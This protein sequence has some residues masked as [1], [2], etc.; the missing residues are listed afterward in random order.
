MTRGAALHADVDVCP[1]CQRPTHASESND[2]GICRACIAASRTTTRSFR[3][4]TYSPD[5]HQHTAPSVVVTVPA[6]VDLND[7]V[8]KQAIIAAA[9]HAGLAPSREQ[10]QLVERLGFL[11]RIR[12]AIVELPIGQ[13]RKQQVR[14]LVGGKAAR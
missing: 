2:E 12:Y 4:S 9:E 1:R 7:R 8:G 6:S 11:P 5:V 13:R 10:L 14:V 3:V